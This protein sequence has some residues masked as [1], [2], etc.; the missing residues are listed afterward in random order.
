MTTEDF[1]KLVD[2]AC[3]DIKLI[4][5]KKGKEY[6]PDLDRLSNFKDAAAMNKTVPEYVL[7]GFV[8][9][10]IVALRDFI[11]EL[12][13]TNQLMKHHPEITSKR[14]ITKEQ[15]LE[16]ITDIINYLVLLRA[17]LKERGVL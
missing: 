5:T 11:D 7:W 17:L 16:K 12:N 8:T 2:E 4:L 15:W 1:N 9:K 13:L 14:E 3:A 10:H 6:S